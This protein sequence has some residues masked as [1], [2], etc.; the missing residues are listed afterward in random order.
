MA[1][2]FVAASIQY[3]SV[4]DTASLDITG[5]IS[6]ACFFKSD[7]VVT[8]G[9]RGLISKYVGSGDQRSYLLGFSATSPASNSKINATLSSSGQFQADNSVEGAVNLGTNT[10]HGTLK[11]IPSTSITNY[12][13]GVQDGQ[14]TSSIAA[15][16]YSG[17]APLWIGIQFQVASGQ[18]FDGLISEAAIWNVALTDDEVASLAKG[19]KPTRVRPQ[20]LVF[21]A[22]LV[23]DLQDLTGAL[24]ITNNNTATVA[25][26]PRVY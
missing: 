24:T 21:Y 12:V 10:R 8:S 17:T 6:L 26:H 3:L 5:E 20:S 1:Y 25:E 11:F 19:F 23:R 2:D 14:I 22:P 16:I 13:D 15:S 9:V 7:G 18:A 4:A